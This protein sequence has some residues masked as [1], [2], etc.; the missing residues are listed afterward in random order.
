[1]SA[2]QS[3]T[4]P[5]LTTPA[6]DGETR[7]G[8]VVSPA[9]PSWCRAWLLLPCL[10]LGG[11][12][13]CAPG[14]PATSHHDGSMVW[15]HYDSLGDVIVP[16]QSAEL[17]ARVQAAKDFGCALTHVSRVVR[18][19]GDGFGG[20]VGILYRI[21]GCG[22]GGTYLSVRVIGSTASGGEGERRYVDL[23]RFVNVS[24][25]DAAGGLAS[26]DRHAASIH[27]ERLDLDRQT[28][29]S[30]VSQ[31]DARAVAEFVA[32]GRAASRDL[33]CGR[34]S[35]AI[36]ILEHRSAPSTYLA[37][38]CG[39]RGLFIENGAGAL[40]ITSRVALAPP[41]SSP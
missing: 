40:V 11:A 36:E 37:E 18:E 4:G 13:A 14:S 12:S 41:A 39:F 30:R 38:G 29:Q 28:D 25:D 32:L 6:R 31:T 22:R 1:M 33:A 16:R 2:T 7:K 10:L 23:R 8:H 27:L 24:S 26:L 5:S 3:A 35:L 34:E 21:E 19:G 9:L 17:A 15:V 20:T